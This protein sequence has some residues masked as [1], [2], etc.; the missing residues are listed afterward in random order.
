MPTADRVILTSTS[1]SGTYG[2]AYGAMFEVKANRAIT[3]E[4][5]GVKHFGTSGAFH[6]YIFTKVR[7]YHST[8]YS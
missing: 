2:A 6:F 3:V 5:F 1:S 8:L 7:F 4:T